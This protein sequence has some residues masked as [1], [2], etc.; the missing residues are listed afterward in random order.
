MLYPNPWVRAELQGA[1]VSTSPPKCDAIYS[2]YPLNPADHEIR[3]VSLHP[4]R[5]AEPIV[6][7]LNKVSLDNCPKYEA[8]SYVW[9][10]NT[11]DRR[12]SV[13][14]H[15]VFIG[16]SL[17]DALRY[18][19]DSYRPR[20]LWIDALSIDQ[21]NM[22]E[23]S[24]Q[25]QQMGLIYKSAACVLA[26]LGEASDDSD[27]ALETM[28]ALSKDTPFNRSTILFAPS[29]NTHA[30]ELQISRRFKALK[31]LMHRSWW[32]RIW[33]V[34]EIA[35]CKEAVI[36]CGRMT[37]PWRVFCLFADSFKKHLECCGRDGLQ[38]S[39]GSSHD[40]TI[41]SIYK[42]ID[43]R[44]R[45][46]GKRSLLWATRSFS[47]GLCSD[48]RDKIY[49]LLALAEA[50]IKL[51]PDY[52]LPV[53]VVY[54]QST[55]AIIE[56]EQT[57]D[58]FLYST[59]IKQGPG[60]PSWVP[61]WRNDLR[62]HGSLLKSTLGFKSCGQ[63]RPTLRIVGTGM[64]G[65][66]GLY[67]DDINWLSNS[68]ELLQSVKST[69]KLAKIFNVC[70]LEWEKIAGTVH[71]PHLSSTYT[72]MTASGLAQIVEGRSYARDAKNT[73]AVSYVFRKWRDWLLDATGCA[74]E[75]PWN[76]SIDQVLAPLLTFAK[77]RVFF[78]TR[79]GYIGLGPLRTLIGD[80]V[81]VLAGGRTPFILR[82]NAK[83]VIDRG[84]THA[85]HSLIGYAYVDGIM[86]GEAVDDIGTGDK[87]WKD[88]YLC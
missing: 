12:I 1:H 11:S 62:E 68:H 28:L 35:L 22:R 23:R 37:L 45:A 72:G 77:G 3:L 41:H 58:I 57:L 38:V 55:W 40:R 6:C 66:G 60:L 79:S 65:I 76:E 51:R 48:E 16:I 50:E 21:A 73:Q 80:R 44:T 29:Q 61:D 34:Q 75:E 59:Y 49:G 10:E 18:L 20:E 86:K 9:G 87:E 13:D 81:T 84:R 7:E 63:M 4:G 32:R 47:N 83:V 17:W 71:R 27:I 39:L 52:T 42:L 2:Q 33:C 46:I 14:G 88:V 26:W 30:W 25:V 82:S 31:K 8:L 67:V 70:F 56:S 24:H 74:R 54:Q 5:N 36:V 19:R 43:N 78:R 85:I 15:E 64:L 53:S 69:E